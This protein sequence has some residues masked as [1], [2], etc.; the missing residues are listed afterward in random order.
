MLERGVE[1]EGKAVICVVQKMFAFGFEKENS[2]VKFLFNGIYVAVGHELF[3]IQ[4]N[5]K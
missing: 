2:L 1:V 3:L 4:K 5:K